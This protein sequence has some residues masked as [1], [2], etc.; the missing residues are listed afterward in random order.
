MKTSVLSNQK[1]LLIIR[2][3]HSSLSWSWLKWEHLWL[4]QETHSHE[5]W[6]E[7]NEQDRQNDSQS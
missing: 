2:I 3:T 1:E 4:D 5:L 6:F 7:L